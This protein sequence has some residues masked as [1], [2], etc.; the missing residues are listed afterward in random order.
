MRNT[1][2]ILA[3]EPE[4]NSLFLEVN[5]DGRIILKCLFKK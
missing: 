4:R 2:K 1:Y 3:G 5:I